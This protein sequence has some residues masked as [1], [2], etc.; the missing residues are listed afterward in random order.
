MKV[1]LVRIGNSRGLRLPR[2]LL[3]MYGIQEG[4]ELEL[5]ELR[6]GI[7]IR[8]SAEACRKMAWDAAYREMAEE[9]AE[10]AERGEWETANLDGRDD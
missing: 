1:G 4:D 9:A 8:P 2:R 6:E 10:A 7:L 5:E 3:E